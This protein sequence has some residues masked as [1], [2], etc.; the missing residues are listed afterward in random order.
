MKLSL[1]WFKAEKQEDA[2]ARAREDFLQRHADNPEQIHVVGQKSPL[3]E[4]EPMQVAPATATKCP[5]C[6]H[7]FK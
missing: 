3:P 2:E 7:R 4:P 5:S 6:G 1:N